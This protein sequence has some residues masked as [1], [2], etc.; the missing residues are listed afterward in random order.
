MLWCKR[1]KWHQLVT[2]AWKRWPHYSNEQF[3]K[4]LGKQKLPGLLAQ[5]KGFRKSKI[6]QLILGSL[7]ILKFHGAAG[8]LK[9]RLS[10]SKKVVFFFFLKQLK[11]HTKWSNHPFENGND[12]RINLG[13]MPL[14]FLFFKKNSRL[15]WFWTYTVTLFFCQL[16]LQKRSSGTPVQTLNSE[17]KKT[18]EKKRWYTSVWTYTARRPRL[19]ARRGLAE[20]WGAKMIERTDARWATR[21]QGSLVGV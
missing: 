1:H 17:K 4:K 20:A 11:S 3:K 14:T 7:I 19:G 15:N 18:K 5:T 13:A 2:A 16:I 6:N 21:L 10:F 12:L 8:T 9:D